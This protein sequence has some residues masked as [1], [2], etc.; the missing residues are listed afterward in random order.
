L[1]KAGDNIDGKTPQLEGN[2]TDKVS[3]RLRS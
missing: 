3:G 2:E 1:K